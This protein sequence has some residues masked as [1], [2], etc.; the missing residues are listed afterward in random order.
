MNQPLF[1]QFR[2]IILAAGRGSR[3]G[4]LTAGKPKGMTEFN[5][6][7]LLNW[8]IDAMRG[9]D[10]DDIWLITGYCAESIKALGLPTLHNPE[11]AA[12]NM[13]ASLLCAEELIDRPTIVS[14]SDIIYSATLVRQLMSS[15]HELTI[16]YDAEW[17]SLWQSRFS[18]PLLDAESFHINDQGQVLDIGRKVSTLSEIQGQYMG[19][20]KLTPTALQ[21]IKEIISAEPEL[22]TRLDMTQLLSRL[23]ENGKPVHGL[24]TEANWCEIDSPEDLILAHE[25]LRTG[26]LNIP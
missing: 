10:I 24:R 19:L 9:A 8:Q 17:L 21:W 13:V 22:R 3:L 16:A 5:S 14:Y 25:L 1:E 20:I 15:T 26:Q 12:S 2:G 23:I 4:D 11:W 6:R 7:P 18:E